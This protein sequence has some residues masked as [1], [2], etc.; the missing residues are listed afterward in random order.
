MSLG[1]QHRMSVEEGWFC[2]PGWRP[3]AR[4]WGR[5]GSGP[6]E[7]SAQ[8]LALGPSHPASFLLMPLVVRTRLDTPGWRIEARR[9]PHPGILSARLSQRAVSFAP[10]FA[11]LAEVQRRSRGCFLEG[12]PSPG[13]AASWASTKLPAVELFFSSVKT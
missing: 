11:L 4:G 7:G 1:G 8:G 12:A 13:E 6:Q 3:V 9:S 5:L 2:G 10:L